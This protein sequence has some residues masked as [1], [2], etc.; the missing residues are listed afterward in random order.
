MGEWKDCRRSKIYLQRLPGLER[1]KTQ[2]I[3]A[4]AHFMLR[5]FAGGTLRRRRLSFPYEYPGLRA[6]G[7]LSIR[8]RRPA[9]G[10][11]LRGRCDFRLCYCRPSI[12]FA[13]TSLMTVSF[14][15]RYI[16][17]VQAVVIAI[18]VAWMAS[19]MPP[20]VLFGY[21]CEVNC[22]YLS[23]TRTDIPWPA[24]PFTQKVRLVLKLKQIPYSEHPLLPPLL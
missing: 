2:L 24:S 13:Y 7:L 19:S 9:C 6:G 14:L 15:S 10:G 4:M 12:L 16:P 1:G 8:C 11:V 22:S 23:S 18:S 21:D 20:V 5:G 17:L 3:D